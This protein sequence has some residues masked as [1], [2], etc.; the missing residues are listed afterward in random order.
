MIL[1]VESR[2]RVDLRV[3]VL[4]QARE[5]VVEIIRDRDQA[6]FR[7]GRSDFGSRMGSTID[8]RSQTSLALT[9][10]QS[11]QK[12]SVVSSL[13]CCFRCCIT[14]FVLCTQV[15]VPRFAVGI[16]IGRNGEM[17]K[18]IQNDAGVRIQFKP[19]QKVSTLF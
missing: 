19:G 9:K 14:V 11:G 12:P 18:K 3:S 6:D 7:G 1:T 10:V 2:R 5:L 4:Q 8:V 16:V 15:A 13:S 17:I